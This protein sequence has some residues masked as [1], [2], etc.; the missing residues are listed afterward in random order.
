[1][2]PRIQYAKTSDGV[3]IA[4]WTL[5]EGGPFVHMP[6]FR[7]SHIQLEWEIPEYRRW[8]EELCRNKQLVRY[9]GR[10]IGMSDRDVSDFSLDALVADLAAVVDRLELDRFALFGLLHTGP[11]AIAYAARYPERVSHLILWC[12]YARSSDYARSSQ[13]RATRGL[14]E[15]DWNTYTETLA[16]VRLGWSEG[17]SARQFAGLVRKSITPEALQAIIGA[18]KDLDVSSLL[19]LVRS[20]TLVLHR[21]DVPWLSLDVA[22]ELASR[23]PNAEVSVLPGS[24][25]APF[26]GDS[27]QVLR[28]ID[29]F[30]G[31]KALRSR[32]SRRLDGAV[33]SVLEAV[34]SFEE[35][36]RARRPERDQ[37]RRK[38]ARETQPAVHTI[39]FTDIEGS[40]ALTERLGD[41]TARKILR[42]HE[43]VI[44]EAL[45]TH[46]GSEI[47]TTGDG[48]MASF[49]SA[50]KALECAVAIQKAVTVGAPL[51]DGGGAGGAAPT[52]GAVAAIR[53]RI[54]LNAGEPIAEDD[55]LFGTAVNL[56]ARIAGEAKGG[57]ILVS[58][59]VRQLV[60]GKG[61][62]FEDRGEQAL[63]GFEE[64]VRLYEVRWR[65]DI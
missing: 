64:P 46:G 41:A 23:I 29:R 63:R 40:T 5:G 26:L 54:G 49:A 36:D 62:L 32:K 30:L 20:P 16:H 22:T 3:N 53:V 48:F 24:S 52:G 27:E 19:P 28:A 57:E 37:R 7:S 47:K 39:L 18:Y 33:R 50:T 21:R 51:G 6:W 43:R 13:V 14:M 9:D 1:M 15:E 61:F 59:V 34:E 10:G 25:G 4:F 12:T 17:E 60:A 31:L 56:A 45:T 55:D 44:R 8:Y 38:S 58:D 2:E 65:K 11:V 42:R 35:R